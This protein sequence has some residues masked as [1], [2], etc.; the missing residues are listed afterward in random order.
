MGKPGPNDVA[1]EIENKKKEGNIFKSEERNDGD[2][3]VNPQSINVIKDDEKDNEIND[4]ISENEIK[5][6]KTILSDDEKLLTAES[7]S[8]DSDKT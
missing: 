1:E 4:E 8:S 5:E 3:I 2:E 6:V 7:N